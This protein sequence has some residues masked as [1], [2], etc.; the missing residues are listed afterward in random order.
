MKYVEK[1]WKA[2]GTPEEWLQEFETSLRNGSTHLGSHDSSLTLAGEQEDISSV[3]LRNDYSA[4]L[5]SELQGQTAPVSR[6]L[7][8]SSSKGAERVRQA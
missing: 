4:R 2:E 8:R 5:S 1:R 3:T 7:S 6:D